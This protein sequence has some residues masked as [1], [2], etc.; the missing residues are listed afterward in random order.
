MNQHLRLAEPYAPPLGYS[1]PYHEIAVHVRDLLRC[2]YALVATAENDVIRIQ[3]IAGGEFDK[4]GSLAVDLV[5]KLR[6]WAPVV[7]DESRLVAVP[8]VHAEKAI[9]LLMGYSA[10]PGTFTSDDLQRLMTYSPVAAG[11]L[12]HAGLEAPGSTRTSFNNEELQHFSRLITIGELSACF[13]HEVTNPLMLIRGHLR[14]VEESLTEDH[15]L[16]I[17]FEVIDR[18]SR[19]IEEMAKRM[20]D[21]SRKRTRRTESCDVAEV[22]SDALRFLQP[23]FR[24]QYVDVQIHVEPRLPLIDIDRWQ[25]VQA[26]VNLL[27]NAADAMAD[28]ERRVLSIY[29]RLEGNRMRIAICDTGTGIAQANL[30]KIFN[31]FFTTKGERGT[32]LGLYIAKQ[33]I[34]EHNGTISVQT[35]DRGT[36]F[37]ISLP[38]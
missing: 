33:V 7:V 29:S 6:D 20:L 4:A 25:M 10:K 28:Q 35:G 21:F 3:A 22:I 16:R 1:G 17:N 24:T 27:Q 8:V 12:D 31:P 2:D 26:I 18:A 32:G 9:G 37:V 30:P 5:S 11:I 23:Y 15:P 36:S 13:A 38:L 19:R 14:F 34:D